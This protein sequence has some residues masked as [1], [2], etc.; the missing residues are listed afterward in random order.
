MPY[1]RVVDLNT[2]F[3]QHQVYDGFVVI[4]TGNQQGADAVIVHSVHINAPAG[5]QKKAND[6]R[7]ALLACIPQGSAA[8]AL[9]THTYTNRVSTAICGAI[10]QTTHQSP[11]RTALPYSIASLIVLQN[12]PPLSAPLFSALH[13]PSRRP[14]I[15]IPSHTH[16]YPALIHI[17]D[18]ARLVRGSLYV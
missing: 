10:L 1:Q 3:L 4:Q 17:H 8:F 6:I 7:E 5:V 14:T 11:L 16:T 18:D 13:N 2:R 12:L 15:N 9:T